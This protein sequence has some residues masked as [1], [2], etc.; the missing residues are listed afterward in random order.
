MSAIK[1]SH[2]SCRMGGPF[3]FSG[4]A[5]DLTSKQ[6][7]LAAFHAADREVSRIENLLTDY[8]DSPLNEI[9]AAAGKHPVKVSDE[10][11][12][13]IGQS[14]A[15]SKESGGVF[16]I[17][18]AA[19]GILWRQARLQ[20]Q[21][22]EESALANAQR[23]VNYRNIVM[24]YS[25]KTIFLPDSAM[26]I[27]L[28][29]VGKGYAVDRAYQ[30]IRERGVRN[31]MVNG[32]GD[33]R[34]HAHES[35]LRPWYI[36]IQNPFNN[37]NAAAGGLFMK[38]GAVATSG[39]YQRFLMHNGIRYHHVIDARNGKIRQDVASVTITASNALGADMYATTVMAL[40]V[41]DGIKFLKN[42]RSARGILIDCE[43]KVH[44]S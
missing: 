11:F 5:E 25:A 19:V 6:V 27:G 1:V 24:D 23:A 17:S 21:L 2:A 28:G 22:P 12:D 20:N 37:K 33:I 14:I 16:D 13:L 18:Y 7:V 26:R 43:G 9:N 44:R 35:L 38:S 40:G 15:I 39:N 36:A 10:L 3:S 42:H 34:T 30:I 32:A 29:G 31:F 8:H 4:F 41:E